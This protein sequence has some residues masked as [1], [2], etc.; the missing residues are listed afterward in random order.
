[1]TIIKLIQADGIL[2]KRVVSP[3]GDEH[4]GPC[5]WCGGKDRFRCW[6]SQG[7]H[8]KYWCRQCGR[9][10][11][12]IQYLKDY[13][14]MSYREACEYL[15]REPGRPPGVGSKPPDKPA[16]KPRICADPG[17]LWQGRARR[18]VNEATHLLWAPT[19]RAALS[20]L[21]ETKGLAGDTIKKF[22]LGWLPADGWEPA[23]AWGL[24][25]ELRDDGRPKKVWLPRGLVIPLCQNGQVIRLRVRRPEGKP[26]YIL[27]PGSSTRGM[28]MG[29]GNPVTILVESELDGL[30]LYQEAGD[31]V[32]VVA[33][34][35]AQARPDQ[36]AA[37]LLNR[38]R[39]I[40]VGLDADQAGAKEAWRWWEDHYP[41]AHR[42]PPIQGK[43][44]GEMFTAGLSL[45]IWVH[46]GLAEYGG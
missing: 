8:G 18:L 15:G 41:Q 24:V 33:L 32:N 16:W 26:R 46:A 30:L 22:S 27:V 38:S 25:G 6:P 39:L 12:A 42:W 3:P 2:T 21:M 29:D 4:A 13:R 34:G 20:F 10:G 11:D 7:D 28:V 37:A 17:E 43:D 31:L 44:P 23:P 35:N 19:G 5:P 40:L 36:E 9:S 14:R 1:M 45:R